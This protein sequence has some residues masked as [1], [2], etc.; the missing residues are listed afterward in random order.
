[1]NTLTWILLALNLLEAAALGFAIWLLTRS[2]REARA[3]TPVNIPPFAMPRKDAV[4]WVV[5]DDMI[6]YEDDRRA[7]YYREAWT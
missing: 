5:I 3:I 4:D 1:M 2:R 6:Q 7:E